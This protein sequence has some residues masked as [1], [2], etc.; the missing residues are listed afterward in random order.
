MP[1]QTRSAY[2]TEQCL[3]LQTTGNHLPCREFLSAEEVTLYGVCGPGK[4]EFAVA[5]SQQLMRSIMVNWGDDVL[6]R[7]SVP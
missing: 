3:S 1:G 7:Q 5:C 4:E 2:D 6:L